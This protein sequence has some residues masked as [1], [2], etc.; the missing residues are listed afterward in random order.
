M[1]STLVRVVRGVVLAL[2]LVLASQVPLLAQA[3]GSVTGRVVDAT[4]LRPLA[5]AQISIP[6]TG[7]GGLANGAGQYLL[8]NVPAGEHTIE[9]QLIG[10]GVERQTTTVQAGQSAVLDFELSRSAI[11]LGEI[12]ITGAGQATERRR[13][14][15][16][17]EALNVAEIENAP[18]VS[19]SEVLQA[20]IPGVDVNT[21]GGHAGSGSEIRIRGVGSISQNN[22]PVI[23]VDG[24]R[25]DGGRGDFG[26]AAGASRLDD[27]NPESIARIE[28]LK[29]AA[30]ATLY[31]T[32]ASNG[33]I[34]IFTKRGQSGDSRWT[35][36]AGGGVATAIEEPMLA[37]FALAA[38]PTPGRDLGTTTLNQYWGAN[39]DPFE[40]YTLDYTDLLFETGTYQE[41]ALSNSG[42]NEL[43]T[44]YLSG[45]YSKEN[46]VLGGKDCV[47]PNGS[48]SGSSDCF[49]V[50]GFDI[51]E[52]IA[53]VKQIDASLTFQ[54]VENLR[55]E[56]AT[57]YIDRVTHPQDNTGGAV[58]MMQLSKVEEASPTNW[59]GTQLFSTI[60]EGFLEFQEEAT[61]RFGGSINVGYS[62]TPDLNLSLTTGLDVV[63]SVS[64][65]GRPFGHAVDGFS[66][67]TPDG[68]R[69]VANINRNDF[70]LDL[71]GSWDTDLTSELSSSLVVGSQILVSNRQRVQA[72]GEEFPGPGIDVVGGANIQRTAEQI[73]KTV[74]NGIFAQEQLGFRNYLFVTVGARLDRHSAFGENA[75][76][77]FYPKVSGSFVVSDLPGWDGLGPVSTLRFRAALGKSGLQPGS[78]DR[79][80]TFAPSS[81]AFGPALLPSNLGNPDLKPEVTT[82]WEAG[83]EAGLL[84]D[85][86]AFE[87]TYW[88]RKTKDLLIARPFPVSGGFQT[89]QLDN[90]GAMEAW[91]FDVGLSGVVYQSGST[92][93]ELFGNGAYLYQEVTDL[94]GILP[95]RQA[96]LRNLGVIREGYSPQSQFGGKLVD[97][98][99]PYNLGNNRPATEAEMLTFLSNASWCPQVTYCN[100]V[101]QIEARAMGVLGLNGTL[102]DNFLGKSVPDWQGAFGTNVAVG[103]FRLSTTFSYKA[104]NYYVTNHTM[105]FRNG[106][107]SI[108][109]NYPAPAENEAI[110]RNPASTPEQRLEAVKWFQENAYSL[111]SRLNGVNRVVPADFVRWRELSLTWDV[112]TDFANS[113]GVE[114]MSVTA[115][116]R[117]LKLWSKYQSYGGI[118]PETVQQDNVHAGHDAHIIATPRRFG[119]SIRVN[120]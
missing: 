72:E 28:V 42:G 62:I 78:F 81:S 63:R 25:V 102:T 111:G 6:G 73:E 88:N 109:R 38:T 105:A 13:L 80:S 5:N 97:A 46:G 76:P 35:F 21:T 52:D 96:S 75:D 36:T 16:T 3:T 51:F 7:I 4:S 113:I 41:Y 67:F 108:G 44:Y 47:A 87:A 11:E 92:S 32:E 33:V 100:T 119:M 64:L 103:D 10:Y 79:F 12:V 95:I 55:F 120:F 59:T 20:R 85:R 19:A 90:V 15:N 30:A 39:N 104:G 94:G 98:P 115:S 65:E 91:G 53:E 89:A 9:V 23:Y 74:N 117:N 56:V 58:A 34:Q 8:L 27:L 69:T 26:S 17:V 82:E 48:P 68:I 110:L 84:D 112:P 60:R 14:G 93:V 54:P 114:S 37:G 61:D 40:L 31:G 45:R 101:E 24:V 18:V 99:Y 50:P 29:G 22:G 107:P 49:R 106:N 2:T 70:T 83:L 57:R 71:S 43:M 116:G 77:A 1:Q 86:V 118:D 66:N